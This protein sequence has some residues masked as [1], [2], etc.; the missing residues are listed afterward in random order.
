MVGELTTKFVF[1]KTNR[2]LE[3]GMGLNFL[4]GSGDIGHIVWSTG[5]IVDRDRTVSQELWN[6]IATLTWRK[7]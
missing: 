5:K 1:L 4:N 6:G 7:T 3:K 2:H